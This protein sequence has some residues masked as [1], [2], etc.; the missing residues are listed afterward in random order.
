MKKIIHADMDAFY[1][2][3]EI[4]ENPSLTGKPVVVGG[5]PESRS[6]VCA[7]SYEARKYGIRSAMSCSRAKRLCPNAIFI[8]PNFS[9]YRTVSQEIQKLFFE[10]TDLVEPLSLDEAYLDVTNNKKNISSATIIA[11]E[12]KEK[13]SKQTQ[14]TISCGVSYNK[15]L[16][17][18]AS[19]WKKPDGLFVIKPDSAVS[20]LKELSIGKFHGIG[21]VTEK[22]MH[23]LGIFTGGDLLKF[24]VMELEKI[25]GIQGIYYYNIVRGIDNREV[26]PRRIRKSIGIEDTFPEDV[27]D[28]LVLDKKLEDLSTRLQKRIIDTNT[29]GK[30]LTLKL[31]FHD[32][33]IRSLSRTLSIELNDAESFL[34][35][36]RKLLSQAWDGKEKLRLVGITLSNLTTEKDK[37][38]QQPGLFET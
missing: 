24:S 11:E 36:S 31:K 14:L 16:A 25:F 7:A 9:L 23:N 21:K 10:Y 29:S 34:G 26:N 3:V 33:T 8:P 32:F 12:I 13:V 17:K 19:D 37:K 18:I 5:S 35:L 4:R 30:T 6:V 20:F 27:S 38:S 2:S 22:K 28:P 15:F 1:A